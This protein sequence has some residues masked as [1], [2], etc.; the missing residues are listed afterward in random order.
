MEEQYTNLIRKILNQGALE[1]T[2]NGETY[3]LFGETM[4]FSLE[5]GVLPILTTKRISLKN[6]IEELLWFIRGNTD[7][8]LLNDKGVHIWDA[9]ASREFLDSR[10][11]VNNSENDLGPIYGHQ[12]RHFNAPY[13]NC[14]DD[15]TGKGVDQLQNIID[16]LNDP[17]QRYSRR[18]IM[19]AWN[20]CQLDEMALP[21]CHIM[22]QFNVV[23]GT[24]T[25][26]GYNYGE[27]IEKDRLSCLLYQRSADVGLGMPYNITS[28][29]LL[30]HLLATHC[31][32]IADEFVYMIGNAHIYKEHIEGLTEQ[33]KRVPYPLPYVFVSKNILNDY[34][35][36]DF[37]IVGYESHPNIKLK[38][39]A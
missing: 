26:L 31:D 4:R 25:N 35:A 34:N 27:I 6:V 28:Y 12:W 19:S 10:G 22:V 32:M 29:S 8:K 9:N 13:T 2:R 36:T 11:L 37:N 21:P 33:I 17:T 5:N 20:P 39:I 38:M 30:T 16:A 1:N 15:Y 7:N 23:R 3:S 24:T 14:H 18:L